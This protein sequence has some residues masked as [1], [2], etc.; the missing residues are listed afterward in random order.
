VWGRLQVESKSA[1]VESER[2]LAL[3]DSA[4]AAHRSQAGRL[5]AVRRDP[6]HRS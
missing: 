5:Q 6:F 1:A 4:M 3:S 2:A